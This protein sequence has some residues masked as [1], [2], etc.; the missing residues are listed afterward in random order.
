MK[1][2]PRVAADDALLTALWERSVRATHDFIAED[3]IQRLYPL[4]RDSYLPALQVQVLENPDASP[5]G[6]IATSDDTVQMLFVEP[7][8]RGQGIGRKL[9]D[10][11][12][13]PGLKVDVNEQNPKA[14][15]FYRHYGF[16]DCGRSAT[17]G[18]GKPFPILH[19]QLKN[20]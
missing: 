17:D 15:G 20:T 4:I 11:V 14:H 12:R 9:L 8:Q 19:M 18:E 16:V 2:R 6:F 10:Q 7:A 3:D 1:I 5:A 13:R